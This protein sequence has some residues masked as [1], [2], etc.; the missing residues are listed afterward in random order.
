MTGYVGIDP[1]GLIGLADTADQYALRIRLARGNVSSPVDGPSLSARGLV[2]NNLARVEQ[3]LLDRTQNLRWRADAIERSQAV[4]LAGLAP[5]SSGNWLA[6]FAGQAVFSLDSWRKSFSEWRSGEYLRLLS[7]AEPAAVAEALAGLD[8]ATLRVMAH[9]HPRLVGRLDGAPPEMRYSANRLLISLEI[10]KLEATLAGLGD[11]PLQHSPSSLIVADSEARLAEYRRWLDEERQILLFDP[12]GDGRVAEVFGNLETADAIAVVVPG[13]SN[14][15]ANFGT[16]DGGFRMNASNLFAATSGGQAATV[17]WL[18][19]DTPDGA[20]AVSRSAAAA[21]APDLA[22]FLRGMDPTADRRMTV[23]AHSY[24]SVLAGIAAADGIEA[25]NLVFVGS[26]GTTLNDA[27]EARLRE[28]G[29]VWSALADGDPIGL[30]VDPLESYRWW[31]GLHPLIPLVGMFESLRRRE[32]LWHGT[33]PASA[34]FGAW[35]ITTK[36]SSGH[37]E[38]FEAGSLDNLAAIVDGRYGSVAL[39]D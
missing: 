28:G 32:D 34:D 3:G 31:W 23:V 20:D 13:M 25:D 18:G 37:S 15:L 6:L 17:A 11:R 16:S 19:Y 39:A 27:T 29:A 24:G 21:G 4:G 8:A 12:T 14:D 35:R 38:Y 5:L 10:V 26:P 36:G 30:G 33:N 7:R 22:R 9:T 1:V 2:N